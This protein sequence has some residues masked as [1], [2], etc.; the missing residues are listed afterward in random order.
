MAGLL[1][2]TMQPSA[3]LGSQFTD[4]YQNEHGPLRLRLPFVEN[5]FRYRAIDAQTPEWLPSIR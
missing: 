3:E 1:Y 5:G 4:W 2:V